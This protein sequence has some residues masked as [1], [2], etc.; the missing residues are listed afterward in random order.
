M[1][2]RFGALTT[3]RT[4]GLGTQFGAH[5]SLTSGI[6]SVENRTCAKYPHNLESA[7]AAHWSQT[8]HELERQRSPS[9]PLAAACDTPTQT[10]SGDLIK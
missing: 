3:N 9:S 10:I 8:A 5:R 7:K 1:L 6:V 4:H 2:F